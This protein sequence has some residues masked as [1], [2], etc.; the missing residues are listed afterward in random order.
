MLADYKQAELRVLAHF[1]ND[2]NMIQAFLDGEDLHQ[3]LADTA[4]VPRQKAKNGWFARVYGAG[5]PRFAET[6]DVSEDTARA[7]YAAIDS[8]F[9]GISRFIK[10]TQKVAEDRLV[11]DAEAWIRTPWGRYQPADLGYEYKL[12]NYLIQSTATADLPKEKAVLLDACGWG[13]YIIMPVHDEFIFDIP[14][15]LCEEAAHDIPKLMEEH[16]KFKVPMLVDVDFY[17]RWGGKYP[18]GKEHEDAS[19]SL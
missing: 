16:E 5:V 3:M 19:D 4:G 13:E 11:S 6:I 10:H 9:P 17:Q 15:D 7:I 2:R 14:E 8:R 1:A 18:D 12:P